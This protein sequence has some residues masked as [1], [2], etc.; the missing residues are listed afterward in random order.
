MPFIRGESGNPK[1]RTPGTVNRITRSFRE[2]MLAAFD[3]LGG[4]AHLTQWARENP[5]DYYR[6]FARMAPPGLPVRIE[7]LDGAPAD[8]ARVVMVKMSV[9]ELSPEQAATIMGSIT[10]LVKVLEVDE[11]ARRL[12]ALEEARARR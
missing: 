11:L 1:G 7:G 10:G 12:T 3:E 5:S 9:G 4:A 6:I 2:A 8:A